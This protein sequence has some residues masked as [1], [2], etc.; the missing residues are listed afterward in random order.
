MAY[1]YTD[2]EVNKM[3]EKE[4]KLAVTS[5]VS[6]CLDIRRN[7]DGGQPRIQGMEAKNSWHLA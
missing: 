2:V 1:A 7:R 5:F 4:L 3:P 6:D